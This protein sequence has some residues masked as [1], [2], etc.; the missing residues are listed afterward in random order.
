MRHFYLAFILTLSFVTA[1]KAQEI[2]ITFGSGGGFSGIAN[3]YKIDS[4]GKVWKGNGT[5]NIGYNECSKIKRKK[6][7]EFIHRVAREVKAQ[8]D[9]KYPGNIYYFFSV[10]ENGKDER[11]TWGD[12]AHPAPES[13]KKIYQ[14]I[15]D[16]TSSLKYKPVK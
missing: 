2:Y 3:V 13:V 11:I 5:A 10:S 15:I 12:P 8:G 7:Q 4:K 9:S 6:A 16:A 1:S 14:E